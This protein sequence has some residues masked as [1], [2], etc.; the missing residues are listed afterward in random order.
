MTERIETIV[1]FTYIVLITMAYFS[2]NAEAIAGIK[3]DLWHHSAITDFESYI[4]NLSLLFFIDLLSFVANG[5]LLWKYCRV[6]IMKS[7]KSLQADFWIFMAILEVAN[8]L[9]VNK[10]Y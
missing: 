1:P 4:Q 2:P 10:C 5:V 3:L 9:E 8:F 6:N 7:L